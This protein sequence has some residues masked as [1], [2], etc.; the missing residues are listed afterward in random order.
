MKAFDTAIIGGGL[1]GACLAVGLARAG[2][3][4]AVVEAIER[5]SSDR[6]SYDDRTLVINAASLNILSNLGL[7]PASLNRV[8]LRHI[9]ITRAGGFGH[10]RLSAG[11]FGREQFGAVIVARELGQVLLDALEDNDRIEVLCPEQLRTFSV[12]PDGVNVELESGE[13]L[14]ARLLVGADGNRSRVRELAGLHC[15]V[16]DYGQSAMIFNCRPDHAPP[17]TA[18]ERFT[19]RGPLALLPQPAGQVGVVWIDET[20]AIDAA[21]ELTDDELSARLHQRFGPSLGQF[22]APGKRARYPLVRQ[23][24]PWPTGRRLVVVGNAANAV[25]PVSA[26]GFNL[27]LRDVGGLIDALAGAEDCGESDRL[28]SYARARQADQEATV[29]YTDTLARGFTNPSLLAQLAGGL[30]LAAHAALPG[31]KRRLVHATM[32]FREPVCSLARAP[33]KAA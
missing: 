25:H 22:K 19:E 16:H 21:M 31:L 8:P 5:Q 18:W 13:K 24:T 32:G 30:G 14:S 1:V 20:R 33:E 3:R 11:E 29:R 7:L 2:R 27:G 6:P 23:R 17:A 12:E 26:Q 9:D 28:Q 10:L 4:I 15:Q